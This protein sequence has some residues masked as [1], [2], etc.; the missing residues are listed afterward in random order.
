GDLHTIVR[1]PNGV[2]APYTGIKTNVLFFEKGRP[3]T[4]TWFYEHPYPAGCKSYSKTKP[5]RIEEFAAEKAWWTDR[6]ETE[7]AWRVPIDEVRRRGFN[8]DIKN[9]NAPE[10]GVEDPDVLL[11]R[12]ARSA[13]DVTDAREAL[14]AALRQ[15][16]ERG[17]A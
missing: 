6:K 14:K 10:A 16:L 13:Q 2:F 9:P 3:T 8:L 7:R 15:A 17:D 5:M 12:Y 4:E 1:L 11:A